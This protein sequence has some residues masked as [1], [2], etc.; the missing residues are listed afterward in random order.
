MKLINDL[1]RHTD[2]H[3]EELLLALRGVVER[4]WFALGPEV[5]SFEREFADYC[6][7]TACVGVASG[8]DAIEL[9]LRALA[10]G[11][12]DTVI[13]VANA[14]GYGS[15]AIRAVGAR[16]LFADVDLSS[17]N[18]SPESLEGIVQKFVSRQTIKA[19]IFTH[20][21]GNTSGIEAV[22]DIC[23]REGV[24]LIEDC[25]QAHGAIASGRKAGAWG[26]MGCFSFY[27]TKN[28]G[29]LGDGG[30]VVTSDPALEERLRHLRQYGWAHSKYVTELCGARNSRLDEMQAAVLRVKLRHLDRWNVQRRRIASQLTKGLEGLRIKLPKTGVGVALNDHVSHLYVIATPLRESLRQYL[31]AKKIG[32]DVHY[33][34]PDHR[35]P[36]WK[37]DYLSVLLPVTERL[38]AEVLTLPCFPEMTDEEVSAIVATVSDWG[39]KQQMQTPNS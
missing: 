2:A 20:L 10:I 28:L 9:A 27:P 21:Y 6:G 32:C 1:K 26:R 36:A 33:P 39:A 38:A 35:Q 18:M 8:T 23:K 19:V 29:A 14:G 24:V 3:R 12:G 25:A 4:G 16:P 11:P 5:A 13:G 37:A 7:A 22:A 17:M 31:I 30:A 34:V 15:H